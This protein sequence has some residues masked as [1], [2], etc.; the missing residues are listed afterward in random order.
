MSE[1]LTDSARKNYAQPLVLALSIGLLLLI[2]ALVLPNWQNATLHAFSATIE[3]PLAALNL[4][5]LLVGCLAGA[6]FSFVARRKT[7]NVEVKREWQT[8]DAKLAASIMSDKE[9]QLE[10]KIAT[11]EAALK[12]ALKKN[13]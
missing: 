12:T 3:V 9:K 1:K 8:Q 6:S 4:V 7:R 5:C 11:L 13:V 10:A 2:L